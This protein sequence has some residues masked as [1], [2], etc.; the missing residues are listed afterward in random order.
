[1][2]IENSFS[3]NIPPS[4]SV[5]ARVMARIKN[6]IKVSPN[7]TPKFGQRKKTRQSYDK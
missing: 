6:V 5:I 4:H 3:I 1:M 2:V 7:W